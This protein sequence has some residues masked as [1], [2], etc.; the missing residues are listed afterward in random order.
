MVKN[1]RWNFWTRGSSALKIEP[2][3]N[4]SDNGEVSPPYNNGKATPFDSLRAYRKNGYARGHT[5]GNASSQMPSYDGT[6][7]ADS[8]VAHIENRISRGYNE[9]R[10]KSVIE[11]ARQM[12]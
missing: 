12:Y 5:N 4:G 6:L 9:K 8:A 7:N 3:E 1:M 2:E 10:L 11:G